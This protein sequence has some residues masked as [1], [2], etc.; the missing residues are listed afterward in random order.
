MLCLMEIDSMSTNKSYASIVSFQVVTNVYF[1]N[2]K[3]ITRQPPQVLNVLN[4]PVNLVTLVKNEQLSLIT[5]HIE[6]S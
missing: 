4:G 3:Q 2:D 1:H 6:T 5:K